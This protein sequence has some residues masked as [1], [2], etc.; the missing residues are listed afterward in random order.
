MKL[1]LKRGASLFAVLA[2]LAALV[3]APMAVAA[4]TTTLAGDGTDSVSGFEA[5][6]G[7]HLE[8]SIASDGTDFSTDGTTNLKLNVTYDGVEHA[9]LNT[10]NFDATTASSTLNISHA[11]LETLPG[12]PGEATTVT[13]NAWGTDGSGTVTTSTDTFQADIV[14]S[15]NRSVIYPAE[16]TN[17][18]SALSLDEPPEPGLF[19]L[20]SVP[21]FGSDSDDEPDIATVESTRSINGSTTDIVV[22]NA[23]SN[24][25]D[26][27]DDATADASSEDPVLGTTVT[28]DGEPVPVFYESADSDIVDTSTD[29]YAVYDGDKTVINLGDSYDGQSSVDVFMESQ[30]ALDSSADLSFEDVDSAYDGLTRSQIT[31]AFGWGTYITSMIPGLMIGGGLFALAIPIGLRRRETEV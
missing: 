31:S 7:D 21:F 19:S 15:E 1:N 5:D 9:S 24:V 6:S 11:E 2:V 16:N 10:T 12:T 3:A 26:A 17:D 29:T 13:V 23:Q 30:N 8:Y 14:F 27:L 4:T 22:Y 28:L 20:S 18:A 25:S